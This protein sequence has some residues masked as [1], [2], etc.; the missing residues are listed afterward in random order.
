MIAWIAGAVTMNLIVLGVAL[1]ITIAS[2]T[3]TR[4]VRHQELLDAA[5]GR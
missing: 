1:F 3:H 4:S 2:I 5:K